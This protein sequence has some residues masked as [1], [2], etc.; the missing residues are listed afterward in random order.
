[1]PDENGRSELRLQEF[2]AGKTRKILTLDQQA[3]L[4]GLTVSPDGR[5]ILYGQI[6]QAGSDLMLVENFR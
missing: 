3:A 5:T 1:M 6:D 2:A 4:T